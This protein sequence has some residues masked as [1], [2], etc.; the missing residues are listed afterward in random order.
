MLY[1]PTSQQDAQE[2]FE[3]VAGGVLAFAACAIVLGLCVLVVCGIR[4]AVR[5]YFKTRRKRQWQA[6]QLS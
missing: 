3:G 6:K 1:I 5:G 4:S 2:F